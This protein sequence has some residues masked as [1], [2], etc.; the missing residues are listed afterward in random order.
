[1]GPSPISFLQPSFQLPTVRELA[2]RFLGL[3]LASRRNWSALSCST[4]QLACS[5]SCSS[6]CCRRWRRPSSCSRLSGPGR[7]VI[8]ARG[9][10][11]RSKTERHQQGPLDE[12]AWRWAAK[13]AVRSQS[14][15][16]VLRVVPV[17]H[18]IAKC[19]QLFEHQVVALL[20]EPA[21]G[22]ALRGHARGE[23]AGRVVRTPRWRLAAAK[24]L[25]RTAQD[26]AAFEVVDDSC[27]PQVDCS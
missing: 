8:E 15:T 25:E 17:L 26:L 13:L 24:L 5:S 21:H 16:W 27:R 10:W 4:T 23:W 6:R 12:L 3:Q 2:A 22:P 9:P 18:Q 20:A 1:M 14:S 11:R 7:G 19:S